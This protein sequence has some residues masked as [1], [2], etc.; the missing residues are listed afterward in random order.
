MSKDKDLPI[1]AIPN[2]LARVW[3]KLLF[4]VEV[5]IPKGFGIGP[6]DSLSKVCCLALALS[7]RNSK[8]RNSNF[9]PLMFSFPISILMTST[10]SC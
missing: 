7:F 2:M 8:L 10:K 5:Q 9:Q 4:G 3:Q 1:T 6:L